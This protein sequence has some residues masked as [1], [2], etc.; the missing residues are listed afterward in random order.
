M[1]LKPP[2]KIANK[3]RA[4]KIIPPYRRYVYKSDYT[5]KNSSDED[6]DYE[7]ED[8]NQFPKKPSFIT[9]S[10]Y[11]L[12][13]Q[14]R[15]VGKMWPVSQFE[16]VDVLKCCL[17]NGNPD[18]KPKVK[19]DYE[20]HEGLMNLPIELVHYI[21]QILHFKRQ[22]K[23]KFLRVSKL[24]YQL[25]M[26]MIYESPRLKA[27]NFFA[28]VDTVSN[29][30]PIGNHIRQLDLSHI[31]QSGKNA[32]VAKLLKRS[33]KSLELFV[34][35]QTS[36][37]LGPLVSLKNC[38]NLTVLD[39]RLVSETLN[40]AQ[41]FNSISQ[42]TKLTRLSFPR[43]SI[44]IE[45]GLVPTIQ[46]PPRLTAL[47][48]LGGI[49]DEFLINSNLPSTITQLEF[50]HCPAIEDYGIKTLLYRF[51]NNLKV[52]K[53]EYPMPGLK[54][55][56]LDII[57]E[58]CPNL[59]SLL[60]YVDYI[61]SDFFEEGYLPFLDH[62]RPLKTLYIESSGMLGTSTKLHPL[63]LAMALSDGRLACLKNI[64]CT[65][66]LGWDPESEFIQ[67]IVDVLEQRGGGMYL[68][69]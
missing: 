8:T 36:F 42:L 25:T 40:L 11:V 68:G 20:V 15:I 39:L 29:N 48:I 61:S 2:F 58:A 64:R 41:L 59:V 26:P 16:K 47:R 10:H 43:S 24:F 3:R 62:D 55:D 34:A 63:D 38:E 17:N 35:P 31:I 33:R 44:E 49:S 37:G 27:T 1:S 22:L 14:D 28:F 6:S 57:F 4:K 12:T 7:G 23:P 46:W 21:L 66:K 60:I 30:K 65:A 69:Y 13:K 9:D 67:T 45:S 50:A 54:E 32:F 56:S 53:V 52:L 19:P 5:G 51:G 18:Y